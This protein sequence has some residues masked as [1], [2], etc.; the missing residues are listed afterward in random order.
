MLL[1]K[2]VSCRL[3]TKRYNRL[4]AVDN[5]NLTVKPGEL[6]GLLGPNGAGKSTLVKMLVG[7][8]RPTSGW[9]EVAGFP[10][11]HIS[12]QKQIGYLPELFRF[13][14]WMTGSEFL[15]FHC[16]LL[17]IPAADTRKR[18]PEV[19]ELTGLTSAT[20][21]RISEYSKGMQQ[22]I[23]IA[24]AILGRPK[25]LFLD[26]PTS[27]LDPVGRV[28]VRELLQKITSEGTAVFLNSHLLSDIER[29]CHRVA[30]LQTGR[31]IKEG[32]LAEIAGG[33]SLTV[34]L[35]V[36][37]EGLLNEIERKFGPVYCANGAPEFQVELFD[38]E[39]VSA[40]VDLLVGHGRKIYELRPVTTSLEEVFLEIFGE[41][42]NK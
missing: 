3:I 18:V 32:T 26:E 10:P 29:I 27:A 11:S 24:Q 39:L 12:A 23:G 22:R 1:E 36:I 28:H 9:A 4:T 5:L 2:A 25:V 42:E 6:F 7:L 16:S 19:L 8:V 34:K 33:L 20:D 37:T 13:P 40:V 21:R 15:E 31:L 17:D 38:Q 14:D 30:I 35:D 41:E